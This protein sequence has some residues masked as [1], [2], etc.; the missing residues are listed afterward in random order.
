MRT[1]MIIKRKPKTTGKKK[2]KKYIYVYMYRNGRK[3][4]I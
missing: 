4:T 2:K 3:A 1:D